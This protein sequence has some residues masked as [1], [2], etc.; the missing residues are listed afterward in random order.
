MARKTAEEIAHAVNGVLSGEF[1]SSWDAWKKTGVSRQTIDARLKGAQTPKE[2]HGAQQ[3]LS[4]EMERELVQ[5]ILFEDRAG[6]APTYARVRLMAADILE[7]SGQARELGECW[8]TSFISRHDEIKASFARKVDKER[9]K[10]CTKTAVDE[11]FERFNG[12]MIEFK[13]ALSN[14]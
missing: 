4:P 9:I 8:H 10:L 13:C 1:R 12:I 3:K 11:F 5:W 6:N 7:A 14:M 2:A